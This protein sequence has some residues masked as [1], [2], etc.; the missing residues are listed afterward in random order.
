MRDLSQNEIAAPQ[1]DTPSRAATAA[2]LLASLREI[3]FALRE[4]IKAEEARTS[5]TNEKDPCYSILARS[6]R[7]RVENLKMTIAT[8]EGAR[9]AA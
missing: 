6:M 8:L 3:E 4:S 5:L 2:K 9:H 1:R 7:A